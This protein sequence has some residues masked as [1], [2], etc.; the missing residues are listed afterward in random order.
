[1]S[2]VL[3]GLSQSDFGTSG[4][5]HSH[6]NV[7]VFAGAT[8]KGVITI[9]S[10][11]FTD[12]ELCL[13]AAQSGTTGEHFCFAASSENGSASVDTSKQAMNTKISWLHSADGARDGWTDF[14]S[15]SA[16]T[17][18]YDV[19][20]T[21]NDDEHVISLLIGGNDLNVAVGV[22][23]H[24]SDT[25]GTSIQ[26]TVGF[27]MTNSCLI[28]FG[29]DTDFSTGTSAS[30]DGLR[31]AIGF[32][33]YDGTTFRQA[34]IM[35]AENNGPA[36]GDPTAY[37][38]TSRVFQRCD[39]NDG[40]AEYA[41]EW[42]AADEDSFT[43]TVRNATASST[44]HIGYIAIGLPSDWR[45]IVS[46]ED[47]PTGTGTQA[48]TPSGATDLTPSLLL[49]VLTLIESAN[50]AKVD[51]EAGGLGLRLVTGTGAGQEYTAAFSIEDAAA[52]T[53]T[54]STFASSGVLPDHDGSAGI[55]MSLDSFDSGGWTDDFSAVFGSAK[56]VI[57]LIVGEVASGA[58]VGVG[59]L[60]TGVV[61]V[62]TSGTFTTLHTATSSINIP[63]II[64]TVS[65]TFTTPIYEATTEIDIQA[66]GLNTSG[67]FTVPIYE[68][69]AA[70][71]APVTTLASEAT[72]TGPVYT[73]TASIDIQTFNF[74][75]SG[76]SSDPQFDGT[77]AIDS[78]VISITGSGSYVS[79][80][81]ASASLIISSIQSS[82]AGTF[83][84]PVYSGSTSLETQAI[85]LSGQG[86]FT[87]PTFTATANLNVGSVTLAGTG[88]A[89]FVGEATAII[90][91]II[92]AAS[93]TFESLL[94]T[95]TSDINIPT[96]GLSASGSFLGIFDATASINT[97]VIQLSA[98]GSYVSNSAAEAMLT[99]GKTALNASGQFIPVK[100]GSANVSAPSINATASGTFTAP[101]YSATC[102]LTAP[103]TTLSAAGIFDEGVFT[104]SGNLEIEPIDLNVS[105]SYVSESVATSNIVT[106]IVGLVASGTNFYVTASIASI[107]IIQ[108]DYVVEVN[109][110]ITKEIENVTPTLE[111]LE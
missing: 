38:N 87:A 99:V 5:T 103:V 105:G 108:H 33:S 32:G 53:N 65:G 110:H 22:I 14:D 54:L 80:S 64:S 25:S 74:A 86:V 100:T 73:A 107:E 31:Q 83:T 68:A 51:D 49:Q 76:T 4:G 23:D 6:T 30:D 61:E 34:S 67:T 60:T 40:T 88:K 93:G 94:V 56:K 13:G 96:V 84:V 97:S 109:E 3:F 78:T 48:F 58:F 63:A 35:V 111:I 46:V 66:V 28:L 62:T 29:N 21:Y 71:N 69:S 102:D 91:P 98:S 72:F 18:T 16:N 89:D 39:I 47:S 106:P 90:S 50:S 79:E 24:S 92:L 26:T 15:F 12:A 37:L 81:I 75:A 77:A 55:A 11:D 20:N 43:T 17:V 19:T 9:V 42:T 41:I 2:D 36:E 7:G 59:D 1:M 57:S 8:P 10:P 44:S 82:S 27:D 104:A 45:A 101:V 70:V 52:T 85:E 95:G